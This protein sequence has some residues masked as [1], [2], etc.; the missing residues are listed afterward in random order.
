MSAVIYLIRAWSQMWGYPLESLRRLFPFKSYF[1]FRFRG[2][3]VRFRCRPMWDNVGGVKF[4]SGMVE[5]VGVAIGIASPSVSV[6]KL[7]P[8]PVST[9]GF[10]ADI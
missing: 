2:R 9:S 3:Q 6:Q 5:N 8:F 7:F 10:V 1:H 4:G